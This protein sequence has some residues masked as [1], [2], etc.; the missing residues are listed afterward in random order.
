MSI[1]VQT[2]LIRLDSGMES[3]AERMLKRQVPAWMISLA[4]HGLLLG[5]FVAFNVVVG[6]PAQTAVARDAMELQATVVE[7]EKGPI[8]INPDPGFDPKLPA[9]FDLARIGD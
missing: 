3:P 9:G 4:A 6:G 2:P 1:K 8:E 7:E 5:L